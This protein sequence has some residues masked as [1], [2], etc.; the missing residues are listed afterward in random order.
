MK[1]I[2]LSCYWLG[3]MS[4]GLFFAPIHVVSQTELAKHSRGHWPN[5][6]E[7]SIAH[8]KPATMFSSQDINIP[9]KIPY[10]SLKAKHWF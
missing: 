7:A 1:H 10:V 9:A 2:R 8:I 3:F 4:L 5:F 6:G